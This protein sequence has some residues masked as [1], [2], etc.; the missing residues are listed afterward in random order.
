[1]NILLWI[2]RIIG[3]LLLIRLL[4]RLLF[5]NRGA[6]TPG[7]GFRR[8][9]QASGQGAKQGGELVRD[10]NCGMYVPKARALAVAVG[11]DTH[12][13]CSAAC[14]DAYRAKASA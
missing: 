13:F 14:R 5:P 8:G 6:A 10:P 2:I 11:P 1:M 12:Y 9:R 3:L 7:G 4:L